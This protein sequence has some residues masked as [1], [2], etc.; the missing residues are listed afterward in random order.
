MVDLKNKFVSVYIK[1]FVIPKALIFDKPG[2]VDFKISGKTNVFARQIL[3][4]E[5]FF[6]ELEDNIV[7][8]YGDKGRMVLYSI[9]KKFGYSFAQLGRFENIKDHGD[10]VKDWIVI[11][12]KFVEGTYA[13][14]I[15]P[16]I[17]LKNRIV[18]YTLKNFVICR[19]LNYDLIFSTGGTAGLMSWLL[20]DNNIECYYSEGSTNKDGVH[21]CKIRSGP[22]EKLRISNSKQLFSETNLDNLTQDT[23]TYNAFN[24]EV[25]I[26]STKSFDSYLDAKIFSYENGIITLNASQERFFLMEASCMYLLEFELKQRHIDFNISDIAYLVGKNMFGKITRDIQ[27]VSELMTALGWGEVLILEKN[28][29]EVIINHFPWTKWYKDIDFYIIRGF[30]SG[31]I[32]N[33]Y[34]RNINFNKPKVEVSNGYLTLL[35]IETT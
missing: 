17:D 11:A 22:I 5:T 20:Q 32:S 2:F 13:S 7:K 8:T 25:E 30:L 18:D 1:Q 35:F 4:P 27:S 26:E 23:Q 24:T 6:V 15:S 33:I 12:S 29:Y 19:K 10:K 21:E 28:K 9:G 16:T 31:L 34:S 3:M 14:E